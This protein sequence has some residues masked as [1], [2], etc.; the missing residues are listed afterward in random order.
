ML[1]KNGRGLEKIIFTPPA[2][3]LTKL[4]VT[5]NWVTA[6]GGLLTCGAALWLFPTG[7]LMAGAIVCTVLVACDGLDGT[8]ARMVGHATKWGAFLDS[9]LDRVADAAIFAGLLL[10][11]MRGNDH[12]GTMA[13]LGALVFAALVPYARARAEGLGMEA[14]T[15][16]AERSDRLIVT[17]LT[18][19]LTG[20]G[21]TRWVVIVGLAVVA[22]GSAITVCQR[23]YAAW[24]QGKD[25][26]N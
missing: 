26:A 22:V 13:A 2:K 3:L 4:H 8:M 1:G 10:H 5:P 9:T 19:F 24:T 12:W 16:I 25:Q 17:L 18:A 14:K 15:G 11:F 20:V 23:V 21:L 6:G 7:H